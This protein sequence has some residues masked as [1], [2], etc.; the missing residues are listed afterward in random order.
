[1]NDLL[2]KLLN[3]FTVVNIIICFISSL[4]I[5][6]ANSFKPISNIIRYKSITYQALTYLTIISLSY[7]IGIIVVIIATGNIHLLW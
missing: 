1:M 4:I 7:L 3:F 5:L 2:I 6:L